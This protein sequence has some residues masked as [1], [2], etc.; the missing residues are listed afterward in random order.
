MLSREE[1][2]KAATD[3]ALAR[4]RQDA[5]AMVRLGIRPAAPAVSPFFPS[6]MSREE[7]SKAATDMALARARQDAE[8]MAKLRK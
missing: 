6:P 3:M 8:E 2:S 7:M 5:E 4:A 1:M